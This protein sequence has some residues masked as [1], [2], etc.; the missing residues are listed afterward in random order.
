MKKVI[1]FCLLIFSNLSVG[2]GTIYKD[3]FI[4]SGPCLV[5]LDNEIINAAMILTI[6]AEHY[7]TGI[8]NF[9]KEFSSVRVIYIDGDFRDWVIPW[10]DAQIKREEFFKIIKE[11]CQK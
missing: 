5:K 8:A 10:A 11:M 1:F 4:S 9:N 3:R 6:T 7:K 2:A